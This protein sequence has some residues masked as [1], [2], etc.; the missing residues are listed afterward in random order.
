V[1]RLVFGGRSCGEERFG[2]NEA[3]WRADGRAGSR[4]Q[5]SSR[6]SLLRTHEKVCG[7]CSQWFRVNLNQENLCDRWSAIERLLYLGLEFPVI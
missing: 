3:T 7:V 6:L 4:Y 2:W 1:L 5:D